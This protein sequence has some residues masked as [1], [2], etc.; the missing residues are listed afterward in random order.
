MRPWLLVLA[1][2]CPAVCAAAPAAPAQ[3]SGS[4]GPCASGTIA[5]TAAYRLALVIGPRKEMYLPS[6]VKARQIKSGEI[7]LGGEMTM[8]DKL[9]GTRIFSLDVHICTKSSG[10]TVTGLKPRIVVSGAGAA[11]GSTN[12]PSAIMVGVGKPASDYHY[13][14]D[15]ALKPGGRITVTVTV[16]G[17]SAAFRATAP[18]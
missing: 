12:V 10:A 18:R 7:M 6:E 1:M 13:G 5:T 11:M 14:N 17:Q 15:V 16:K 4:A 3:R 9:P 8:V 2:L